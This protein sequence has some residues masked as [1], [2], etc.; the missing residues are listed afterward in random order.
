MKLNEFDFDLPD[1]LVATIPLENRDH[2]RLMVINKATKTISHRPFS[3]IIDYLTPNDVLVLND[4]KVIKSR[5]F[6][7]RST[8][9]KIELLLNQPISDTKWSVLLKP[10]N[11][12]S[13]GETLYVDPENT[14]TI[15]EKYPGYAIAE[16]KVQHP[17]FEFLDRY[18]DIPL[19][20]Y[21]RSQLSR[22]QVL[23]FESHYQTSYAKIPGA[24]AAPTA[25]LHF[26]Q[27]LLQKAREKGVQIETI[28]LHIGLGTFQPITTENII[29]H[30]I[31]EEAY[32]IDK[33]TAN[34]L[35]IALS[36]KPV[37]KRLIAVGT[38]SVR[39]LESAMNNGH[40]QD[41]RQKTRLFIYPGYKFKGV[42]AMI[43]NFH[44]PKS[45]LLVLISAFA[46]KDLIASAYQ[47][48]INEQYRFYSFGDSMFIYG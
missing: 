32:S 25:G 30:R 43:T 19:P 24:V 31:H 22:D 21:I 11:R 35:T 39:A 42:D 18:G 34:R 9:G 29:N 15:I 48:A 36:G 46:G 26:T 28:T 41:G 44:L 4:T 27:E 17:F 6:A 23:S 37:R 1:Q 45:S 20:P 40:I 13:I 38:T 3:N 16:F 8:G 7:R 47:E 10:A 5:L 12:V 14:L 2:S 33:S